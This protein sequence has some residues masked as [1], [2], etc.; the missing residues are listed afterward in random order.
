MTLARAGVHPF[1]FAARRLVSSLDGEPVEGVTV[2][3][4]PAG[5]LRIQSGPSS[6]SNE[7]GEFRIDGIAQ[8]TYALRGAGG[9]CSAL[10][11]PDLWR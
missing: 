5:A 8:D 3:A 4:M 10:L 7:H 2:H 1:R 11:P 9:R 6:V